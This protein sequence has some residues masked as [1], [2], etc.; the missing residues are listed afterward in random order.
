MQ[1][2]GQSIL[3]GE[4]AFD[5][6][7]L[8]AVLLL[9]AVLRVLVAPAQRARLRAPLL[10]L[11]A[12]VIFSVWLEF[13]PHTQKG[14]RA[15]GF[16]AVLV[17]L[18]ALGRLLSV[19]LLDWLLA[20]RLKREP[21]KIVRD[22][23]EGMLIVVALLVALRTAGVD[24]SSLLTTSALLTAIVGLS[25]QD[26]LGN[27][28]AGLSLQA[29][30][31][32]SVGEWIQLDKEAQQLGQVVEVNWRATK[33]RTSDNS[34]LI[35]PNG[36]LARSIIV[37]HSRPHRI[38]RRGVSVSVPYDFPVRSVR[39]LL[40]R[41]IANLPGVLATPEPT[42]L[43]TGF[44]DQGVQY[45]VRYFVGDFEQRDR[46]DSNVRD[47]LWHALQRAGMFLAAPGS[48][49]PADPLA[50]DAQRRARDHGLK[51]RARALRAVDFLKDLPDDAIN[52][53]S[54]EARSELY[55]PGEI[56]VRQG[57]HGQELYVCLSGELVVLH[58][59]DGGT[60]REIAKLTA[61][62]LFGEL[63]LMTGAP[64]TATVQAASACELLVIGKTS[65]SELLA[66]NPAFAEL[67]SARLAERQ[68]ALYALEQPAPDQQRASIE[69][70]K[71][72]LLERVRAF[73]AL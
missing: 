56:V 23:A 16:V 52:R 18:V 38:A 58:A 34:E 53:L 37:N 13:L 43:T 21:P 40:L 62:G 27:L 66:D 3:N 25:L 46:I 71:T 19:L 39:E 35:V 30:Q 65:F 10:L 33:L 24:P 28:F 41:S 4:F 44:G 73:F 55:Q 2:F 69:E 57:D 45:L 6:I 12:Y 1:K 31:P 68:A 49:P 42:V 7:G 63:S 5:G 72:R 22:I 61:G 60:A 32:F 36:Q 59:T 14:R 26:T 54:A 70:H 64:R 29:Q 20:R 47:Q 50:G 48:K 11:I 15:I 67:I 17:L 8:F 9:W 51:A